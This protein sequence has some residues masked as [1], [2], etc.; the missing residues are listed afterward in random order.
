MLPIGGIFIISLYSLFNLKT[1]PGTNRILTSINNNDN[2]L[3]RMAPLIFIATFVTHL[4]GGSAGR[5]GALLQIGGS[6]GYFLAS[7]C[8]FDDKDKKV[9]TMCG[10]SSAFAAVFGTPIA[11]TILAIEVC[12]I[13]TMYY[14]ALVPC[15]FASLISSTLS[16]Y[17]GITA[18][19]F[20][21]I[22]TFNFNTVNTLKV[23]LIALI[24]AAV[25]SLFCYSL[26]TSRS[27]FNK[28]IKN[29][30]IIIVVASF[31]IIILNK[32]LQ[33]TDYMGTGIHVIN[34]AINGESKPYAFIIKLLLTSITIGAGFKGG[35]IFPSFFIGA[36]LGCTLGNILGISPSLC[37]TL[38]LIGVFC[39]VTNCPIT[40]ILLA[41]ELFGYKSV[42]FFLI[43]ISIT[44]MMSG[45][46]SL[47][48]K[49]NFLYKKTKAESR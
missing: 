18:E 33:T 27:L 29:N 23:I 41:F 49:Q 10:M 34:E 16:S 28:Y 26:R 35:E 6:I 32:L 37:A 25:S 43:V 30:Y 21:I 39:G 7:I 40:S 9:I 45:Y 48:E 1:D 47:Y 15:I 4:F 3:L 13:G 31:I 5:A 17:L 20:K 11:A 19:N 46:N 36:T 2:I 44:Y 12:C 8:K 14:S 22:G 42:P 38:G 24:C